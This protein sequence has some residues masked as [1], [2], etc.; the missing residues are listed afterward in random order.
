MLYNYKVF[1]S[2]GYSPFRHPSVDSLSSA[3]FCSLKSGGKE[4]RTQPLFVIVVALTVLAG[5]ISI[6]LEAIRLLST[7]H[8]SSVLFGFLVSISDSRRVFPFPGLGGRVRGCWVAFILQVWFLIVSAAPHSVPWNL[9]GKNHA[10]ALCLWLSLRW[11][12]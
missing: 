12:F 11:P 9:A 8:H 1:S 4:P 6:L 2:I 10:T 7:T 3:P 5:N